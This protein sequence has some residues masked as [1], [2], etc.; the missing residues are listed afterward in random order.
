MKKLIENI[1][2]GKKDVNGMKKKKKAKL[3][4]MKKETR[5]YKCNCKK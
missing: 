3:T 1:L 2:D 4:S 5:F